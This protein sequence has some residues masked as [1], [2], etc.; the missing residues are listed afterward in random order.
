ML[1]EFLAEFVDDFFPV[2]NVGPLTL[3]N[4][5]VPEVT[6]TNVSETEVLSGAFN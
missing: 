2:S 6:A 4:V 5:F 1:D 3:W